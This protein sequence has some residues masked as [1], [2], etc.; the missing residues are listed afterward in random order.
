[1]A[2]SSFPKKKYRLVYYTSKEKFC[3]AL[4]LKLQKFSEFYFQKR[5]FAI[6]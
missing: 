2:D 4:F 6:F 5:I 3:K 1:L